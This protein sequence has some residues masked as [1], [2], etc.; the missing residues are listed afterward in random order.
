VLVNPLIQEGGD[1]I[2][3][4][5]DEI[6]VRLIQIGRLQGFPE[7]LPNQ[8]CKFIDLESR[9][10]RRI[11]L[12]PQLG[13]SGNDVKEGVGRTQLPAAASWQRWREV[14]Q[15]HTARSRRL[16]SSGLSLSQLVQDGVDELLLGSHYDCSMFK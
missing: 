12:K 13:I 16:P 11:I 4:R 6:S 5:V 8:F 15:V 2:T 10:Q 3:D 7:S 9:S 1:L 14:Y